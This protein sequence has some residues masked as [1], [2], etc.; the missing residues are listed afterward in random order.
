MPDFPSPPLSPRAQ[1]AVAR[2]TAQN[3]G[4]GADGPPRNY[5]LKRS[6]KVADGVRRIAK[7]RADDALEHLQGEQEEGFAVAV[8]EARKDLKKIRS[9]LRLVRDQVGEDVHRT[10]NRRYRDAGRLLSAPR[11]AEVKLAT[12]EGLR[13]RYADEVPAKIADRL[14]SDLDAERR[15]LAGEADG[16]RADTRQAIALIEAG[17]D[18][19]S[20]WPLQGSGW[21]LVRGGLKRSYRSGRKRFR[22]TV[23]EPS[24]EAV[25]EWR[26]RVKDLWYHLRLVRDAWRPVLAGLADEAHE[27]A[28]LL[29]DHHDLEVL[30]ADAS[31]RGELAGDDQLTALLELIERRQD[32]LL[33]LAI[34]IGERLYA[35]R[36]KV[37]IKRA[38]CYWRAWRAD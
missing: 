4:S 24:P 6:E 22:E 26:K 9:L 32:E 31:A 25:H 15:S 38:R 23:A 21:K 13:Q 37:F 36:P 1:R 33:E 7:G 2:A 8:H 5:R 10:E 12:L 16:A 18:S 3:N 28:D 19:I 29:G 35:E 30:G 17:R 11:D 27:L 14:W 34:P 20:E